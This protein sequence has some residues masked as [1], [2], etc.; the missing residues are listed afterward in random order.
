[1]VRDKFDFLSFAKMGP[2]K[3][4]VEIDL[5]PELLVQM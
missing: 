5:F 3:K 2:S 4:S 1:M